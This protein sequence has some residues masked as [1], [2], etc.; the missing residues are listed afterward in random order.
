MV[1]LLQAGLVWP[2]AVVTAVVPRTGGQLSSVYELRAGD[3]AVIVKVYDEKWRWKQAKEAHV[4]RLLAEHGIQPV[5]AVLR[6]EPDT[7]LIGKAF[8]VMT[9]L[10][11][12]PLSETP[13]DDVA[14]VYRQLGGMLAAIHAIPQPGF[15]YVT[16]HV[17]D[18]VPDNTAYMGRQF[19]KK[20]R[21]FRELQGDPVL[22]DLVQHYVAAHADLFASCE[23][24]VLC[25]ND[26]HEGNVL[27]EDGELTGLVDIEN[28]LAGDPW[29]DLAKADYYATRGDAAK[30]TALLAG[31]GAEPDGRLRLYTIYHAL[32]LWD[33]FASIGETRHLDGIAAD[34]VELAS[35][36]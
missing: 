20:L 22:H 9:R 12:T 10:P 25:H 5:P 16:T 36:A 32:E 18:P 24:P 3:R 34:L 21:E 35:D 28:A 17:L 27:V 19:A 33:W 15:G 6:V 14:A 29:L 13:V 31:Y 7:E 4:Y 30:L 8:T 26:V 2:G 11:G 1:D 23:A